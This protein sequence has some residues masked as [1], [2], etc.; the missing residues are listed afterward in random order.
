MGSIGSIS[1]AMEFDLPLVIRG[2]LAIETS[3]KAGAV[4]ESTRLA[5]AGGI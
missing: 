4:Q 1:M 2:Q 3:M 5:G